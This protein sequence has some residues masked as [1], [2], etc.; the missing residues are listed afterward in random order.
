VTKFPKSVDNSGEAGKLLE[1]SMRRM[2]ASVRKNRKKSGGEQHISSP[3]VQRSPNGNP[4]IASRYNVNPYLYPMEI[5][6]VVKFEKLL[7]IRFRHL[8]DRTNLQF[9]LSTAAL[10]RLHGQRVLGR[11]CESHGIFCYEGT[12]WGDFGGLAQMYVPDYTE[13]SR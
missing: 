12:N 8:L 5:F 2:G 13:I 3:T 6:E 4:H 7:M 9:P 10:T 1:E 11:V